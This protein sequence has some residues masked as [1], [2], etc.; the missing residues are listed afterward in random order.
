MTGGE[1]NWERQFLQFYRDRGAKIKSLV[2]VNL[3]ELVIHQLTVVANRA[4][5]YG[6][7]LSDSKGIWNEKCL[8]IREDQV[9][10]TAEM[11]NF[12]PRFE[13]DI[14]LPHAE[15][16]LN[17]PI[18]PNNAL[19]FRPA[20]ALRYVTVTVPEADRM[21][22]WAGYHRSYGWAANNR[23]EGMDC[24]ALVAL[25]ENLVEP[26]TA[27]NLSK[28]DRLVRGP[29]P[30]LFRDFFDDFLFMRIPVKRKRYQMQIRSQIVA[31]DDP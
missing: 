11:R 13:V 29:R 23:G 16:F 30:P 18:P 28:F 5:D 21:V 31:I 6:N 3:M 7:Q 4:S 2:K 20:P 24:P 14:N 19:C 8:P 15:W 10:I 1:K 25:A 12:G 27:G 22:L 17:P 26:P 9:Q